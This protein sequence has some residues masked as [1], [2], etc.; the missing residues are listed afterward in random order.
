M[1]VAAA[2]VLA[3]A[4]GV[5]VASASAVRLERVRYALHDDAVRVVLD[6]SRPA[7]YDVT[8]HH[9]PE[10][11][12]INVRGARAATSLRRVRV[13]RRG[14]RRIRVNRLSWGVQVVVDLQR[15]ARWTHFALPAA[16]GRR[17]RIVVD[18]AAG[19][20]APRVAR[21]RPGASPARETAAAS[22]RGAKA[23]GAATSGTEPARAG[24]VGAARAAGA[25]RGTSAP[26]R[27]AIDAGH[28]GHDPGTQGRYGIVEKRAA[29]DIARRLER[30]LD[31]T[32]GFDAVLTRRSDVY[33]TLPRRQEIARRAGADAFVSIHLNAARN[34][35][36]RGAEI[37]FVSPAG[38]RTAA[39]R[40]LH[41]PRRAAAE[42]GVA[43]TS[44]DILEMV[45]DMSQQ[46]VLLRS[47]ALAAS[48]LRAMRGGDMP[49]VRSVKQR[50]FGVLKTITIPSVLVEVGFISNAHDA[51][52]IRRPDGRE[53]AAEA[54]ARGIIR[55]FRR[56]PPP[57]RRERPL[58]VH[59]VRRG[60]TLW[61]IS[62]RYGTSV[63]TLVRVN[64]LSRASVLRVGQRLLVP[65]GR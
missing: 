38:A 19:D 1:F 49:P 50:S 54:I 2:A 48:I 22:G 31:A 11:L 51:R 62:R 34:R 27:V 32:P 9:A 63:A 10:R 15:P 37:F 6:L 44:R 47:E 40:V 28:G 52:I 13:D 18:V 65:A 16:A 17:D 12:A 46:S 35:R 64:N 42:L 23:P 56:N 26:V 8:V 45:A 21:D 36:A 57:R 24:A 39:R 33:L 3:G 20:A 14:V 25:P 41:D 5:E 43:S 59:R 55:Y 4:G 61:K 60:E 7:R 29:L 58:Q 53:R 30:I